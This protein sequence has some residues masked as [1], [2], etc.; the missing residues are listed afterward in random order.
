MSEYG[1]IEVNEAWTDSKRD[2]KMILQIKCSLGF[3]IRYRNVANCS[4]AI[5]LADKNWRHDALP[6]HI[7]SL[8][9]H[10]K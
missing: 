10:K 4:D 2:I 1:S 6:H 3:R 5:K 9:Q 7:I 8:C